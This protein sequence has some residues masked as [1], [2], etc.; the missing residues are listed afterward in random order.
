[1]Y[2]SPGQ[3]KS[4]RYWSHL[5]TL[6]QNQPLS[7]RPKE[8]SGE[9]FREICFCYWCWICKESGPRGVE[10]DIRSTL[11]TVVDLKWYTAT[12]DE[13]LDVCLL[14]FNNFMTAFFMCSYW[15][16]FADKK[17]MKDSGGQ[18]QIFPLSAKVPGSGF[19]VHLLVNSFVCPTYCFFSPQF[20]QNWTSL[21][22]IHKLY[23]F[24]PF[25][26]ITL[27]LHAFSFTFW[28]K[29]HICQW[30]SIFTLAFQFKCAAMKFFCMPSEKANILKVSHQSAC[31]YHAILHQALK[32]PLY[33]II[34]HTHLIFLVEIFLSE[35][36]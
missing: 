24:W 17:V 16:Q 15:N 35:R 30:I 6:H 28:Q 36:D 7:L 34:Y 2:F 18:R 22:R 27:E 32:M 9:V 3:T 31:S 19:M 5:G 4:C 26:E 12:I 14:H 10:L 11:T 25:L 29:K 1:M 21:F 33:M 23:S 8:I 13:T 20:D